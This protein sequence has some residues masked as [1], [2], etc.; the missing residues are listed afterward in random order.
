MKAIAFD[1]AR[2]RL[3]KLFEDAQAGSPVLLVRGGEVVGAR[4]A[5]PVGLE[6]A[7]EGLVAIS[8]SSPAPWAKRLAPRLKSASA[9]N[10]SL[11]PKVNSFARHPSP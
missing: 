11:T 4:S 7:G 5:R 8:R 10:S 3:D 9:D 6:N 1:E 2:S